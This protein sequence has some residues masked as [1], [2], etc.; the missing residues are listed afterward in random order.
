MWKGD[1]EKMGT[2][3]ESCVLDIHL[4]GDTHFDLRCLT[5]VEKSVINKCQ[6]KNSTPATPCLCNITGSMYSTPTAVLE[7][8]LM[9]PPFGSYIEG[10]ARQAIYRLTCSGE[11]TQAIFG[12]SEVFEKM[13]D[14]CGHLFWHQV[15][16]SFLLL[17]LKGGF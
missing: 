16:K 15:T 5:V 17:H 6:S 2:E 9:L 3:T 8:K 12:H 10:V 7:G 11:F 1:R 14:E 13:T 4:G